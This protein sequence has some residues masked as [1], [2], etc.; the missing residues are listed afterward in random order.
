M[1]KLVDAAIFK[2]EALRS[3]RVRVPPGAFEV[4][5]LTRLRAAGFFAP[6]PGGVASMR[7]R[8]SS[9]PMPLPASGG[10]A[11]GEFGFGDGLDGLPGFVAF[12]LGSVGQAL[13]FD[14]LEHSGG[15]LNV[16]DAE[17]DAMIPAKIKLR[18][19]AL[20]VLFADTVK[21]ADQAA[22]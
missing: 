7:R 12:K 3:V 17:C 2:T 16:V 14:A 20:Q 18:R 11:F 13:A 5:R 21:C 9:N 15:T 6:L 22:L 4:Y 19:I 8:R 10:S 1:A